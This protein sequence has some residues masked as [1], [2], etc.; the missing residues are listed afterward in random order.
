MGKKILEQKIEKNGILFKSIKKLREFP[1]PSSAER[2]LAIY[3][4]EHRYLLC[5]SNPWVNGGFLPE[6]AEGAL[7]GLYML[8]VL[9]PGLA[10][11]VRRMHDTGRSGWRFFLNLVPFGAIV[12]IVFLAQ[13]SN[14]EAN[15]FGENPKKSAA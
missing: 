3:P 7:G 15:K 9:I 5:S 2:V 6:G 1:W 8:G 4:M 13:D 10:V 14:P 11:F 12:V